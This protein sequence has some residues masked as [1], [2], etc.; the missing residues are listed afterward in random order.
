VS[1]GT[2][3]NVLIHWWPARE[4]SKLL[5]GTHAT[6]GGMG[7]LMFVRLLRPHREN[8]SGRTGVVTTEG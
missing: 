5:V 7:E 3:L 6:A 2:E 4:E 8:R 1:F